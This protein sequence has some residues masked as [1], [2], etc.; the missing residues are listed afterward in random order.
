[1]D[2]LLVVAAMV[3]LAALT[4]MVVLAVLAVQQFLLLLNCLLQ[5][6]E[7]LL[8]AVAVAEVEPVQIMAIF[9]A[10]VAVAVELI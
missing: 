10:V 1:M 3:A 6:T 7:L 8:E 4:V 9:M 5:I 2:A